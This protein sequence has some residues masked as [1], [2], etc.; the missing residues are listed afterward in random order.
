VVKLVIGPVVEIDRADGLVDKLLNRLLPKPQLPPALYNQPLPVPHMSLLRLLPPALNPPLLVPQTS[1]LITLN[2]PRYPAPGRCTMR[3]RPRFKMDLL[4][5]T[6]IAQSGPRYCQR[7][8]VWQAKP[9]HRLSIAKLSHQ[10][11][12]PYPL[13]RRRK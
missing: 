7:P 2:Q 9:V 1:L 6:C 5:P 13:S 3:I 4:P 8:G 10:P 12:P 11:R